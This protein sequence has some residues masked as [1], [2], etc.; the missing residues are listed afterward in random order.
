MIK[1]EFN[2]TTKTSERSR[3]L[4]VGGRLCAPS[5]DEISFCPEV[6]KLMAARHCR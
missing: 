4:G 2:N 5:A 3:T 1:S 6:H